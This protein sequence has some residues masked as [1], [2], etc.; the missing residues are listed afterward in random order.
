[1]NI[2][3]CEYGVTFAKR[4]CFLNLAFPKNIYPSNFVKTVSETVFAAAWYLVK[5][6]RCS[7]QQICVMGNVK[8]LWKSGLRI[9]WKR[10]FT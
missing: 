2:K 1:M 7:V 5:E 8:V 9:C 6:C 4:L 3:D 10:L